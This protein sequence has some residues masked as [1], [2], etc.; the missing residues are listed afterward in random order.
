M[1]GVPDC[2][3]KLRRKTGRCKS[4]VEAGGIL[5]R[6]VADNQCCIGRSDDGR[7]ATPLVLS[8]SRMRTRALQPKGRKLVT[9]STPTADYQAVA[10][11]D[12]STS[13]S[14]N[15]HTGTVKTSR[16]LVKILRPL[17]KILRPLVKISR[18]LVKKYRREIFTRGR[19]VVRPLV[20]PLVL[21]PYKNSIL[22]ISEL[23]ARCKRCHQFVFY[24]NVQ[25]MQVQMHSGTALCTQSVQCGIIF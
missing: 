7:L 19:D 20:C 14:T 23:S 8:V 3:A 15:A 24:T 11:A 21:P 10:A 5:N 22:K 18:P 2:C 13:G 16:P 9:P 1:V 25:R 4:L 12:G 6:Q 17:V